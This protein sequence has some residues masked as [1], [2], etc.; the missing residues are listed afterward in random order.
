MHGGSFSDLLN[1]CVPFWS[2][3]LCGSLV[4]VLWCESVYTSVHSVCTVQTLLRIL[5]FEKEREQDFRQV[6]RR[7][8][9]LETERD[10]KEK[11]R[12]G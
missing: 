2:L 8:K 11:E 10:A 9:T 12:C 5:E 6:L 3:V 1:Q 4:L 7:L